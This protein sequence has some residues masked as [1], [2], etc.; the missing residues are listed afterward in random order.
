MNLLGMLSLRDPD[1]PQELVD[2]VSGV[3]DGSTED[4]QHIVHVQRSHDTVGRTLVRGHGLADER[5]V[6]IV[7]SVIVD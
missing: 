6:G 1:H 5:D 3:P 2:V 7:P 4:H